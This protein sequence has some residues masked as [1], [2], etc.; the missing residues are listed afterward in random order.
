M[1]NIPKMG[2][3]YGGTSRF[4]NRMRLVT[5]IVN[6]C[7]DWACWSDTTN[8]QTKDKRSHSNSEP[9]RDDARRIGHEN[10][11]CYKQNT[12]KDITGLSRETFCCIGQPCKL[13]S[14]PLPLLVFF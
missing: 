12:R 8:S 7:R 6:R 5:S 3:S 11:E 14:Q 4:D 13:L 2:R 10:C 1:P 9:A